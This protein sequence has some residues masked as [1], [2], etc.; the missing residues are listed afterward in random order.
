MNE[1]FPETDPV[2][3]FNDPTTDHLDVPQITDNPVIVTPLYEI[4]LK[5]VKVN[6][7]EIDAAKGYIPWNIIDK[8]A[9]SSVVT[10]ASNQWDI[11]SGLHTTDEIVEGNV[12]P[13]QDYFDESGHLKEEWVDETNLRKSVRLENAYASILAHLENLHALQIEHKRLFPAARK[14]QFAYA[15]IDAARTAGKLTYINSDGQ[16]TTTTLKGNDQINDIGLAIAFRTATHP[17]RRA[18]VRAYT[19]KQSAQK[20]IAALQKMDK[21]EY[22]KYMI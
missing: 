16:H 6:D 13:V 18:A 3:D 5:K 14:I 8:L 10:V 22:L 19:E 17:D 9:D 21:N 11:I 20:Q 4:K 15:S 12:L 7:S 1:F 2:V